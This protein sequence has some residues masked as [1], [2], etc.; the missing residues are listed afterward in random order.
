MEVEPEE[1][2]IQEHI[3]Q[4][5]MLVDGNEFSKA[6]AETESSGQSASRS[7]NNNKAENKEAREGKESGLKAASAA[8]THSPYRTKQS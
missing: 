3:F 5:H 1:D 7:Q 8:L 4:V 6:K 2:A